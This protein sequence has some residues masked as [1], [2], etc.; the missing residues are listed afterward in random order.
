[1][2]VPWIVKREVPENRPRRAA[3]GSIQYVLS[4]MI[5][6]RSILRWHGG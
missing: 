4:P 1:M 3:R 2:G 6:A 5:P